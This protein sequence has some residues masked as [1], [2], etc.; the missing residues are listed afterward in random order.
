MPRRMDGP[1]PEGK[2]GCSFVKLGFKGSEFRESWGFGIYGWLL[3][4]FGCLCLQVSKFSKVLDF[5]GC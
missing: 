3:G 4:L 1:K 5:V 2:R